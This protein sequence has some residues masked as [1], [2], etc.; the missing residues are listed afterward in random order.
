MSARRCEGSART[1]PS[2]RDVRIGREAAVADTVSPP[3]PLR[4]HWSF[5]GGGDGVSEFASG[6]TRGERR[7]RRGELL[8]NLASRCGGAAP[9]ASFGRVV[10]R[11][12]NAGDS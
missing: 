10:L 4:H 3:P 7:E 9:G 6:A 8:L 12:A 5:Q 2:A 1:L 11:A